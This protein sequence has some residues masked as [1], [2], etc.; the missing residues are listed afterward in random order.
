MIKLI[1]RRIFPDRDDETIESKCQSESE[2]DAI[3]QTRITKLRAKG[4]NL[5]TGAKGQIWGSNGTHWVVIWVDRST[6]SKRTGTNDRTAA[7]DPNLFTVPDGMYTVEIGDDYKTFRIETA[8]FGGLAG[9][10]IISYLNGPDNVKHYKGFGFVENGIIRL[11]TR[12][13]DR[14]DLLEYAKYIFKDPAT[15]GEAFARRSGHC[16]RCGKVLTVPVSLNRGLGPTCAKIVET[17]MI[18]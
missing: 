7:N 3:R 9:R 2:A 17:G 12:F 18:A 1:E 13:A 15:C 4:W 16:Y 14:V 11:W 5:T 8:K 6:S 10:R